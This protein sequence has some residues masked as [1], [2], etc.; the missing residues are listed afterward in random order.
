MASNQAIAINPS[1]LA[2][3]RAESGYALDRIAKRLNVKQ[4]R[5]EAWEKGERQ[6]TLR[7]VENLA[8][9]FH[10]PLSVFFMPRPPQLPPLA[11]EYRR[12]P[13]VEPGH[14]SPELRL[15]LRQMIARRENALNLMGELGERAPEFSLRAHLRDSPIKVGQR[16]RLAM[17][18]DAAA[19]LNWANEWEAWR[20]W[21]AA[22]EQ[23]GVLVF[24]FPKVS[25]VEVR[26]LALL[27]TPM[28]VA[29]VNGKEIPEA[30]AFTLCHEV[31]HLML[32]AENE[33]AS[34]ARERRG[35]NEWLEVERFA[36]VAASHA[37]VPEDALR[38]VIGQLGLHRA[39][40]G[41]E[42]VR[43]VAKK[44]RL[45][46]LATATRLRESGFMTWAQYNQW[47]ALWQAYVAALP[48]RKSGFATPM[49]K[50]VNR[51]GRPF[52]QLVLEA[53]SANRITSVDAAR[54]L[55]LKFEHFDKLRAHL[56]TGPGDT[57]ADE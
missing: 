15:A 11:T 50:A 10:R 47:R 52:A 53:L 19:Q 27:R 38:G 51:A 13:D 48:P 35:G 8:R 6:P 9:F 46:P 44:F 55:D 29:A 34:A 24:Q 41:I 37:L 2:W 31:V 7:Q 30:K 28:P 36:E 40:W 12:L 32:A 45:T 5:V 42:N 3:A 49:E 17:S 20:S 54:Y 25:L 1:L 14:E 16:L 26:G 21:R 33:E 23:L 18:V 43:R 22:V 56:T 4:E 57:S 39:E